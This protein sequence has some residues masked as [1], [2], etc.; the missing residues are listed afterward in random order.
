MCKIK[1][2]HANTIESK[3]SNK[4]ILF[5]AKGFTI[6]GLKFKKKESDFTFVSDVSGRTFTF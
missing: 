4:P 3:Q 1:T 2:F 6:K 5:N